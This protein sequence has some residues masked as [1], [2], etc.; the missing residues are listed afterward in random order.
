MAVKALQ[1]YLHQ[2]VEFLP[3]PAFGF[4]DPDAEP[5]FIKTGCFEATSDEPVRVYTQDEISVDP[6]TVFADG[7]LVA[8]APEDGPGALERMGGGNRVQPK[9]I[10]VN[11][12]TGPAKAGGNK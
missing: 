2:G 11:S 12:G 5:F 4:E 8:D 9:D 7:Q 3:G 10:I 1:R 6:E